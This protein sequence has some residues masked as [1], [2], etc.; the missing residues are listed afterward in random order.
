MFGEIM[1]LLKYVKVAECRLAVWDTGKYVTHHTLAYALWDGSGR[2]VFHGSDINH[3]M[4]ALIDS[5][6]MLRNVLGWL[7]L[8]PGDTDSDFFEN[9]T[10]SQLK[11]V[12]SAECEELQLWSID[13]DDEFE[14]P[15][16]EDIER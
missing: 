2:L 1:K 11:W 3:P 6:E 9:Y 16:F 12:E 5:D 13:P 10:P 4:C 15:E 7:T 8:R 14:F